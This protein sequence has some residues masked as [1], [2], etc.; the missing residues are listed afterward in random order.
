MKI[1]VKLLASLLLACTTCSAMPVLA[2]GNGPDPDEHTAVN[3]PDPTQP[4]AT[5][6]APPG[7]LPYSISFDASLCSKY[8]FQGIDYSGGNPVAQPELVFGYKNFSATGWF[9]FQPDL[10]EWNEVDLT[11]KYSREVRKLTVGGGYNYLAYP[12]REGWSPSQELLLEL[13][14]DVPLHPAFNVHYDF[15]SGDGAYAQL[16]VSQTVAPRL[17]L[18]TNLYYQSHYYAM[19]GV[20]SVEFK[21]SSALSAGTFTLTPALSYFFTRDN[22]DFR[23]E[24]LPVHT[25]LF[26]VN[27]AQQVR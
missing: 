18:G 21:A 3:V 22:G 17:S 24:A 7:E 12:H 8:L 9:N 5:R 20:P 4:E 2:A 14:A 19:T 1:S 13:S 6:P 25:W 10:S 23:D 16:G 15:D 27:F 11:V 26:A